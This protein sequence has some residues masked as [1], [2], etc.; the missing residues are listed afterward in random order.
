MANGDLWISPNHRDTFLRGVPTIEQKIEVFAAQVRGW[1]FDHARCLMAPRYRRRERSG[2]AILMLC[3]AYFET[4]E[5]CYQGRQSGRGEAAR[6][7]VGGFKKV[8]PNAMDEIT[9]SATTRAGAERR[10]AAA[11]SAVYQEVRCGLYHRMSTARRVVI[12]HSRTPVTFEFD[13]AGELTSVEISPR[14]FFNQVATHFDEFVERLLDGAQFQIR[15]SFER[16]FDGRGAGGKRPMPTPR[17][18]SSPTPRIHEPEP[19]GYL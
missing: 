9:R 5:S 12:S 14:S 4:L 3:S 18:L 19:G 6:F 13:T 10:V 15:E 16:Y 17:A 2:F 7:F 1:T 11:C 8:F